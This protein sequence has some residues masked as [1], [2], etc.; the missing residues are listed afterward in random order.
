MDLTAPAVRE[1]SHPTVLFFFFYVPRKRVPRPLGFERMYLIF[2]FILPNGRIAAVR[3][4]CGAT[5]PG[6]CKRKTRGNA[7]SVPLPQSKAQASGHPHTAS[8]IASCSAA[9]SFP[10]RIQWRLLISGWCFLERESSHRYINGA[11]AAIALGKGRT[12][13]E[14]IATTVTT[15][16]Q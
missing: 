16:R 12:T 11:G 13:T 3:R 4:K 10:Y 9:A 1:T 8:S 7:S 6:P 14:L 15:C 2:I 5:Q